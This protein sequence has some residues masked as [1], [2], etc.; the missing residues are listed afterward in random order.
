MKEIKNS[1]RPIYIIE[2]DTTKEYQEYYFFRDFFI[3]KNLKNK[4]KNMQ[5]IV[6]KNENI[7]LIKNQKT[8]T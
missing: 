8:K 2:K 5:A 3:N 1:T 4:N 6:L 7:V